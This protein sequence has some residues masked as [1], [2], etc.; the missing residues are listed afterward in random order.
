M[1][2][3]QVRHFD[4]ARGR[5]GLPEDVAALV[6]RIAKAEVTRTLINTNLL[7]ARTVVVQTGAYAEHD[8]GSKDAL[9]R[10]AHGTSPC[11]WPPA[12]TAP[13]PFG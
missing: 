3:P 13:S 1:G 9:W 6:K 8:I 5:S 10:S 12:Q 4:P 7:Q 11:G 2:R